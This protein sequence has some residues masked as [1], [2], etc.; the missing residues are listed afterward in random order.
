[1]TNHM[2]E[3]EGLGLWVRIDWDRLGI[4]NSLKGHKFSTIKSN[5]K[6]WQIFVRSFLSF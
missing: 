5:V 1:M 3:R 6:I 2:Y 4:L